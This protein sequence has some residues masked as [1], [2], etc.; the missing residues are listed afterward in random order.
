M[1]NAKDARELSNDSKLVEMILEKI[2]QGINHA[3]SIGRYDFMLMFDFEDGFEERPSKE[4][5]DNVAAQLRALGY[6]VAI[7][8]DFERDPSHITIDWR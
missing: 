1:M 7:V 6:D 8:Y 3:I 5:L 4:E 2:E